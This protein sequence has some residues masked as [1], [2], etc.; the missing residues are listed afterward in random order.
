[1]N[2]QDVVQQKLQ[3]KENLLVV[4]VDDEGLLIENVRNAL[5]RN[6][7]NIELAIPDNNYILQHQGFLE[8]CANIDVLVRHLERIPY[9][10]GTYLKAIKAVIAYNDQKADKGKK[11]LLGIFGKDKIQPK[12]TLRGKEFSTY[13]EYIQECAGFLYDRY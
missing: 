6:L 5:L 4:S 1:M 12:Y 9:L 7:E 2:T 10:N 13:K 3:H 8:K 11:S